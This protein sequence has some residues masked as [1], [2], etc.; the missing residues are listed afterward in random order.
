M[1][2]KTLRAVAVT[3]G[4]SVCTIAQ[5]QS[6]YTSPARWN[7]FRPVSDKAKAQAAK[8]A[9]DAA[10]QEI[11][12]PIAELPAPAAQPIPMPK[13]E[14]VGSA[15]QQAMSAPW[16]GSANVP[17]GTAACSAARP[18]LSPWFGSA[19]LL[20]L[21]L[22]NG[23]GRQIASGLGNDFTTDVVDPDE[24]VGFDISA[25]KYLDCGRYG[26]GMTYMLW[27]PG[28]VAQIRLGGAGTIR[29]TSPAYRDISTPAG[30]V[31]DDISLNAAGV[32]VT[33]D[34]SFQGIEANLFSF[35]LMGAQR[36]SYANCNSGSCMGGHF[37]RG[38]G[39]G[40]GCKGYG[41]AAGP[42]VRSNCGRIRVM[43]SHGFRWFQIEDEL[44][45]A[46]NIDGT[47]GY[48]AADLYENVDVENN[49]YGYQFGGRL[50]YCINSC[51]NLNI[52]G[53]FGIYGNHAE[54]R[55][56]VGTQTA[57]A[58]R[59]GAPTELIDTESS[60]TVLAT[61][62]ELDLGLGYRL[63]CAWTV[64]GGYKLLGVSGVATSVDSLPTN[65]SSLAASG[66]VDANDSYIVHGGY[67][68]LEYNW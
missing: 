6:T 24:S 53:K 59:T 14:P 9:A 29:A 49:L 36:T 32:R 55:H 31:Y 40:N 43:T 57:A 25:G 4:L 16:D 18:E 51:M 37:G 7:N 27:N 52:G 58:Y 19:N 23:S 8:K 54:M 62:G 28:S 3:L 50:T 11:P 30:T 61:L 38:L 68:G 45:L 5:A 48:Q 26:L 17:C 44:E 67:V 46:Y 56:R 22:A 1:R 15:Y 21:T 35:G 64:R 47:A 10:V 2:I 42:L 34:L 33:R 12:A 13:S 66:Q 60:D 20:F 39:L 63:G 41:G 65:Y